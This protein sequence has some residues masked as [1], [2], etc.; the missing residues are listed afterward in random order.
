MKNY[1]AL[2]ASA[3]SGK[4][5]ALTVRYI[6]LLLQ[7]AKAHEI[8]TLTFTN[9]A[10]N[11]MKSRIFQT[12]LNLGED[13]AYFNAIIQQCK[14]EPSVI[15]AKKQQLIAHFMQ[16]ELSIFT[17]DKFIN[18]ILR[19]FCGYAHLSD[20]FE[21]KQDN[22]EHLNLKFIQSLDALQFEQF[23]HFF[24]TEN[25]KYGSLFELFK[26]LIEKNEFPKQNLKID[27]GLIIALQDDI[28]MQASKIKSIVLNTPS[29]SKSAHNAVDFNDFNTLLNKGKTWLQ[30]EQLCEF[31]YFKKFCNDELESLFAVL[32]TQ[33]CQ[34]YKLRSNYS[35]SKLLNLFE[36][37]KR[38]RNSYLKQKNYLEFNDISNIVYSLLQQSIDKDFLYF[39]LDNRYTHILIDEFQDTSLLQYKILEP[40]INEVLSGQGIDF[41]TFFYVGDTKQ[42]IYRFR[43]GRRELFDYVALNNPQ[44]EVE[45]LHT[46]FRSHENI[47]EF[48][49][50][51]FLNLPHYEYF[52]QDFIKEGGFVQ[53]I[54]SAQLSED[55]PFKDVIQSLKELLEK[56]ICANDI[57]VLTYTN[58]DVLSLYNELHRAFPD[59]K[60]ST[61]MTSKLINQPN[62]SALIHAIKYFYFQEKLYQSNCN[63]LR[64]CD[65][66][67]ALHIP[68]DLKKISVPMLLKRTAQELKLLDKNVLKLIELSTQYE[69][70]VDFIY[71]IDFL[72]TS[73]ENKSQQGVQILTIFKSK[74]LEFH[75]VLLLD[76]IKRKNSDK[77]SL[78]FEYEGIELQHVYYKLPNLEAYDEH[79]KKALQKE[80][81]LQKEDEINILYVALTR[82]QANLIVFKKEKN[83]V[84]EL[85]NLEATTKGVL[86]TQSKTTN[87]EPKLKPLDYVPLNLGLQEKA[88]SRSNDTSYSLHSKYFGLATHFCLEMMAKFT[89]QHLIHALKLAQSKYSTHLSTQD[90][91]NISKRLHVLLQN[92]AF[93]HLVCDAK[94]FKEQALVYEDELKIIDLLIYKNNQYHIIDYKTTQEESFEHVKQ[95]QLYKKAV[96]A[97]Y[98]QFDVAATIVYLRE[99]ETLLKTI[100]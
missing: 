9:K 6:C 45:A 55:E 18:K 62:V 60:I 16:Q 56:G 63:A 98:P 11:E 72:D 71:E 28:V 94:L 26:L 47:I 43:G 42:S 96:Q 73:I 79:Y 27:Y 19:E 5:F 74:G 57:A 50:E 33:L 52:N 59:L 17:L 8:L 41:K 81:T 85:L 20:S 51:T 93:A 35:L 64:G 92:E 75:T 90:F 34:Y 13:E 82:A 48:V 83:S 100:G 7:G 70:L 84:F 46:N 29:A 31:S 77:S 23:I 58:D 25:K 53:V 67:T 32:K 65:I 61:E 89:S 76:R 88:S 66:E 54:Q 10:A 2:K 97:I 24:I 78:L 14:L 44:I 99:K 39:R 87:I 1:L 30:K 22:E 21:I 49:N 68:L 4:T 91:D 69:H 37:F 36:H 40:L 80:K 38:F 12:L 15:M 86:H 95:V 3:G